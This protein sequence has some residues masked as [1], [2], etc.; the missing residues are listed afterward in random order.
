MNIELIDAK[1]I[2]IDNYIDKEHQDK[3]FIKYQEIFEKEKY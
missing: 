2:Y 3:I 1:V